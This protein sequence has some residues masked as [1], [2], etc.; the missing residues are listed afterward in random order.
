[1]GIKK[2]IKR[3]I[4]YILTG[5]KQPIIYANILEKTPNDI[6]NEKVILVTGGRKRIRIL[7]C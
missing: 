7:H 3:G 5:H 1:M 2:Y 6:F 4:K